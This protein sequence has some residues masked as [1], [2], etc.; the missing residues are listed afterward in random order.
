[1][2]SQTGAYWRMALAHAISGDPINV[3]ALGDQLP[4][5]M[6]SAIFKSDQ[7]ELIRLVLM[8]GKAFPPHQVAGEIT[9]HC[10]EGQID[11]TVEGQSNVLGPGQMLFL[12][13]GVPHGVVAI[14]DSSALV[15]IVLCK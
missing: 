15:T 8:A 1:M 9:V 11:V 14:K 13:G 5:H 2:H 6:T 12:K 10:I 3:Q 7:L 4:N